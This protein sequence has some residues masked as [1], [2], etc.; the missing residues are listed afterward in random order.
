M[1]IS[2]FYTEFRL[3]NGPNPS[4]GRIEV[5]YNGT[6][7]TVCDDIFNQGAGDAICKHLGFEYVSGCLLSSRFWNKYFQHTEPSVFVLKNNSQNYWQWTMVTIGNE[8]FAKQM[9]RFLKTVFNFTKDL[10]FDTNI[11]NHIYIYIYM[12]S[13]F[14]NS[15]AERVMGSAGYGAG[16]G[17]IWLDNLRCGPSS[18]GLF[19]CTHNPWGVE[20]CSHSED[21]GVGC[22]PGIV[23]V[24]W[25]SRA[26]YPC[27]FVDERS[28]IK[29]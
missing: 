28:L 14:I 15:R 13:Y 17:T 9:Q 24:T 4:S 1:T 12:Y 6:W 23:E 20:D 19:N 18:R 3:V 5:R 27:D 16:S 25:I 21:A 7:G 26:K 8:Q 2:H 29:A 22:V 11:K 10:H